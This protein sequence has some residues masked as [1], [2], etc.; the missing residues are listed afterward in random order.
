MYHIK[1]ATTNDSTKIRIVS[2]RDMSKSPHQVWQSNNSS[3]N[4]SNLAK[5][6]QNINQKAEQPD[7]NSTLQ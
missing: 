3:I 6:L 7:I 4:Y 5:H 2:D 1:R